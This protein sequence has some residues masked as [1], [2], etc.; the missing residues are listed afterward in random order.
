MQEYIKKQQAKGEDSK[1]KFRGIQDFI[2]SDRRGKRKP[3][4][5]I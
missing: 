4:C 2:T 5:I 1:W 3:F